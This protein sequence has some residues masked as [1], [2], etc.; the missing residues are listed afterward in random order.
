VFKR[1]LQEKE[2]CVSTR[3]PEKD[4]NYQRNLIGHIVGS[5][6]DLSPFSR[7][8]KEAAAKFIRQRD[9][10]L[11][12]RKIDLVYQTAHY[13]STEPESNMDKKEEKIMECLEYSSVE[14]DLIRE[15]LS[16]SLCVPD[17]NSREFKV[18]WKTIAHRLSKLKRKSP[19]SFEKIRDIFTRK[20]ETESYLNFD[21]SVDSTGNLIRDI[22]EKMQEKNDELEIFL[23]LIHN[24]TTSFRGGTQMGTG[25]MLFTLFNHHAFAA[26]DVRYDG[27]E[28]EFKLSR[29]MFGDSKKNKGTLDILRK[30]WQKHFEEDVPVGKKRKG[31]KQINDYDSRINLGSKKCIDEMSRFFEAYPYFASDLMKSWAEYYLEEENDPENTISK[32]MRREA[33]LVEFFDAL[34]RAIVKKEFGN[35][36]LMIV[37]KRS[38]YAYFHSEESMLA[39]TASYFS[40]DSAKIIRI[41]FGY[42]H[43]TGRPILVSHL[44]NNVL[45]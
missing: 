25:E 23:N 37:D 18:A 8:L 21:L 10:A 6:C 45:K 12:E 42:T 13:I 20:A 16:H 39:S 26:S 5:S 22:L 33:S 17:V 7:E 30:V 24:F 32:F 14:M 19:G 11:L 40:L 28:I 34:S 3:V 38:N 43:Q 29:A 27:K 2:K 36:P 1:S 4:K 15:A 41:K 35:K 9:S 44:R 31:K